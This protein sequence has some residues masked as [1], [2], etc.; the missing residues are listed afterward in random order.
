MI[1]LST[2]FIDNLLLCILYG[3]YVY[4]TM[5]I[6]WLIWR[7][8]V[9]T[10]TLSKIKKFKSKSL[11]LSLSLSLFRTGRA[12]V[13]SRRHEAYE[14]SFRANICRANCRRACVCTPSLYIG[15]GRGK[16]GILPTQHWPSRPVAEVSSHGVILLSRR[17]GGD[18]RS[19]MPRCAVYII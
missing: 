18:A 10:W 11:S 7:Y 1:I 6:L 19:A 3:Y 12:F 17:V 8:T 14:V 5:Y 15:A 9:Q 4:Y 16:K 13:S 2:I